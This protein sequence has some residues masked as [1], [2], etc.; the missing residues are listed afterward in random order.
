MR[1]KKGEKLKYI[2]S[3]SQNLSMNVTFKVT[4]MNCEMAKKLNKI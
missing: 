4:Y 3:L 1:K 2:M